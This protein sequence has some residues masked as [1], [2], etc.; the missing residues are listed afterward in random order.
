VPHAFSG[1]AFPDP[2]CPPHFYAHGHN[3]QYRHFGELM[4]YMNRCAALTSSGRHEI[5]VAVLYHGEAEWAEG[6]D[7][8]PFEKPLRRL[9]DRQIDCHVI[10]ADVFA[11]PEHYAVT[12]G[13]P[14]RVHGQ[15]YAALVVPACTHL[16]ARAA[17][18]IEA[19]IRAGLPVFFV[20]RLPRTV[21][22]TGEPVSDVLR[23]AKCVPLETL[24]EEVKNL[25]LAVPTPEP[26]C[27]RLRFLHIH[28]DTE[29]FMAVNEA[30][31]VYRGRVK[32]PAEG[33]CF[34]YDPWHN[35]CLPARQ[36]NGCVE[37]TLEPLKSL[38]IVFGE[39][40]ELTA[41]PDY[42]GNTVTLSTWQRSVCEG[43]LY[44]AFGEKKAVSLP[45]GLAREM[46][47]FSGF[48][49]YETTFPG[50]EGDTMLLEIEDASEGVEVFLNGTSLGIQIAPPFRYDLTGSLQQGENRLAIEVAT[51]LERQCYPMMN[52]IRR[53]LF[54]RPAG[55]SGLTGTVRLILP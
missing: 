15:E 53:K 17:A 37:L 4:G 48:V 44:P 28:G 45:D 22:E 31:D 29:L 21:S 7:A 38:F 33:A 26:A 50:K 27:D 47:E 11:E 55:G 8:M 16:Y 6:A 3:P 9:Y 24:C 46:P 43:S 14:L 34:L 1:K 52:P 35:R 42:S 32:L 40:P 41:V 30:R 25:G 19:L 10:P 13:V 39:H 2:D 54:P 12:L 51:T 5:P 36:E 18:G 23:S 49:R 20:D